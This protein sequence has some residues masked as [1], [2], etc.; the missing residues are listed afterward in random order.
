MRR[1]SL[2]IDGGQPPGQVVAVVITALDNENNDSGAT[3]HQ[4]RGSLR[5]LRLAQP[6][7]LVAHEQSPRRSSPCCTTGQQKCDRRQKKE[8]VEMPA[9][10]CAHASLLLTGWM[11]PFSIRD[12]CMRCPGCT[13]MIRQASHTVAFPTRSCWR[14]TA[15]CD[16]RRAASRMP[17]RLR[18]SA[19][20]HS[21]P[22]APWFAPVRG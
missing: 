19:D 20:A 2:R 9:S 14:R 1:I 4:W 7:R 3:L 11:I 6:L 21:C 8:D 13:A 15:C 16:Q 18:S 12:T 22:I 5:H 10:T 17:D